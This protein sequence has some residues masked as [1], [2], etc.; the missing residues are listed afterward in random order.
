VAESFRAAGLTVDVLAPGQALWATGGTALRW[1]PVRKAAVIGRELV[2]FSLRFGRYLHRE[3]IDVVHVNDPRG[4]LLVGPVT[5]TLGRPLVA[6]LRG[7]RSFDGF[8]WRAFEELPD[9]I[10]AVSRNIQEGLSPRAR[11]KAVAIHNGTRDIAARGGTIQGARTGP[12]GAR[13]LR[14][15]LRRAGCPTRGAAA[16]SF[17][18]ETDLKAPAPYQRSSGSALVRRA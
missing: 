4:A 5:R 13:S 6:H 9:R 1:S 3:R 8:A 10:I 11:R 16:W 17:V 2:P 12:G 7:E 14:G 15:S 18:S